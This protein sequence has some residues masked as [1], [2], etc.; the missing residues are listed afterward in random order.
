VETL[1]GYSIMDKPIPD[2]LVEID[3]EWMCPQC[4]EVVT[5]TGTLQDKERFIDKTHAHVQEEHNA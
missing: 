4:G 2:D 3:Y 1:L 5:F